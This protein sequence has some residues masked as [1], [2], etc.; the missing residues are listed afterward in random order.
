[1][2][3]HHRSVPNPTRGRPRRTAI[4]ELVQ[5]APYAAPIID[6]GCDHGYIANAVHA[7]G[8]ERKPNRLPKARGGQ[9]VVADGLLPYRHVGMAVIT[10]IGAREIARILENGPPPEQ[11][12]LHAPDRPNWLRAWL[13]DHGYQITHERLAPEAR[14]FAEIMRVSR[15][16]ETARGHALW[17]GPKLRNDPHVLAHAQ[18]QL[19][20]WQQ[21]REE[22]GES[23][24]ERSMEVAAWIVFL[25]ALLSELRN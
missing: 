23:D 11:A 21:I 10:G 3:Q 20:R 25:E 24:L 13:G 5:I 4:I 8:S 2:S 18:Q 1:M 17:F 15:S 9:Y 6:V 19:R 22:V 14:G 16:V 7:I 12:V